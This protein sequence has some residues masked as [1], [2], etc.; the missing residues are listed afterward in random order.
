MDRQ[1]LNSAPAQDFMSSGYQR[2]PMMSGFEIWSP[3]PP[4]ASAPPNA[5]FQISGS[6]F[7]QVLDIQLQP[8]EV[9]TAEPGSMLYMSSGMGLEA[10]I[11]GFGQGCKRCCCAGESFFRLHLVNSSSNVSKVGLTPCFPAKIVPIDLAQH[12]GLI[13]NRGAFLGA[14]GKNWKIN[15]QAVAGLGIACCGGQGLF[16]NTL[17]GEGMAFLNAGGTVMTRQLAAGEQIVVDHHSILAFE[18][19]VQLGIRRSGGC[20]VCCCAGQGL[21]NATLT[22]PGFVMIH[23]MALNKLKRAVGGTAAGHSSQVNTSGGA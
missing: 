21:F 9:V 19:T 20:M 8:G 12:S 1:P 4:E 3:S 18:K 22:G 7:S 10:D 13:V 6:E 11:G 2:Q 15:L 14:L 16:M 17:H 23:T 5:E